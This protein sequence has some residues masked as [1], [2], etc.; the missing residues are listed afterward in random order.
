LCSSRLASHHYMNKDQGHIMRLIK[1]TI[2]AV[3]CCAPSI[4]AFQKP[5]DL[6]FGLGG[7]IVVDDNFHQHQV[8]V[9]RTK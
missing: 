8:E 6:R 3:L 1:L 9:V 5:D 7:L 4:L 2:L